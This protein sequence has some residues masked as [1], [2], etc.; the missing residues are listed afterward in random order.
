[1][2]EWLESR[3]EAAAA[4]DGS[5]AVWCIHQLQEFTRQRWVR[6]TEN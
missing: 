4:G 5:L 6:N 3:A 1:M 2:L